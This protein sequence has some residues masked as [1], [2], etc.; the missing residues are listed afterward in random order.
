MSEQDDEHD[1]PRRGGSRDALIV[2]VAAAWM[3]GRPND[4]PGP[5]LDRAVRF[6]D[7]AEEKLGCK[8]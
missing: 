6:V 1:R 2:M 3:T 8:F 4:D 5:A 7:A